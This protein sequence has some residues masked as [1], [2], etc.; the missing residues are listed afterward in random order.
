[1]AT[2]LEDTLRR[3]ITFDAQKVILELINDDA[4]KAEI[5]RRN[6]KQI[7]AGKNRFGISLADIAGGYSKFTEAVHLGELFSFDGETK[8]KLEGAAP[9]L[10]DQGDFFLSFQ[11]QFTTDSFII[12]ADP[13][14]PDGDLYDKYGEDIIGLSQENRDWLINELRPRLVKYVRTKILKI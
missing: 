3:L 8:Q 1:M 5:I 4:L 14:K 7:F 6:Q 2:R 11:I 12:I 10:L 9:F 13:A